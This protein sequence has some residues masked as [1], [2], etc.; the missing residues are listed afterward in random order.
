MSVRSI[1]D[2]VMGTTS[3]DLMDVEIRPSGYIVAVE[4]IVPLK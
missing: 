1:P 2:P 3:I 4:C